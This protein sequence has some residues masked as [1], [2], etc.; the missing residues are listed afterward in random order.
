MFNPPPS[1][2]ESSPEDY[3]TA[4]CGFLEKHRYL[5][6]SKVT[7]FLVRDSWQLVP[8]MWR[9]PLLALTDLQVASV[10]LPLDAFPESLRDFFN[11]CQR[12]AMPRQRCSKSGVASACSRLSSSGQAGEAA[13]VG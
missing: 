3:L 4:L 6:D 2:S 11:D 1:M 8:E 7:E 12:L 5:Y 13:E 9:E 10:E